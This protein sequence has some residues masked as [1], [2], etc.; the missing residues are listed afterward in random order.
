MH[1]WGKK[2]DVEY[3]FLFFSRVSDSAI[4]F[5]MF[6][7]VYIHLEICEIEETNLRILENQPPEIN[8][9][10]KNNPEKNN[11]RYHLVQSCRFTC[12]Q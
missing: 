1:V 9:Q 7:L 2:N 4:V 8:A 3:S 12:Q 5:S 10:E 11:K 6:G